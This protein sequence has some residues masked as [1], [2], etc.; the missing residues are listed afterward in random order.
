MTAWNMWSR[1]GKIILSDSEGTAAFYDQA[2]EKLEEVYNNAVDAA[3]GNDNTMMGGKKFTE[4]V[5]DGVY[6]VYHIIADIS[7]YLI[8]LSILMGVL[9]YAC[10]QK[11]KAIRKWALT[12][13][14]ILLPV[15]LII[16]RFGVGALIGIFSN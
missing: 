14:I 9:V 15:T 12:W 16:F 1:A 3:L 6:R 2:Q 4:W 7:P 5:F 11:N 10:S 13:L 8:V